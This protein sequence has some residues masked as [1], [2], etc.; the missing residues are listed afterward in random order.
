MCLSLKVTLSWVSGPWG[1]L[2][3]AYTVS[4]GEQGEVDSG[5]AGGSCKLGSPGVSWNFPSEV[6]ALEQFRWK[7]RSLGRWKF[8][9]LLLSL[10]L[11]YSFFFC[12]FLHGNQS[13]PFFPVPPYLV[14]STPP[15]LFLSRY[16]LASHGH[17]P[18][19]SQVAGKLSPFS[20]ITAVWG[21]P[22]EGG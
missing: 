3:L 15:P 10:E 22:V 8:S 19:I 9:M 12:L 20:S 17:Q 4:L 21:H 16:R 7:V 13:F 1:L 14:P 6:L 5:N 18:A 11:I 2:C